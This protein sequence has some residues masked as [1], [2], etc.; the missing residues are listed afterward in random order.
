MNGRPLGRGRGTACVQGFHS[1]HQPV[2]FRQF[3]TGSAEPWLSILA[4]A[5]TQRSSSTSQRAGKAP[6]QSQGMD[7]KGLQ[8]P[9]TASQG[10]AC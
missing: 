6:A 5:A 10:P 9:G 1:C 8:E 3:V 4:P 7:L 2:V